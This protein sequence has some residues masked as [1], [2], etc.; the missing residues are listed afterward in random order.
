MGSKVLESKEMPYSE[1]LGGILVYT[2][3]SENF[4][5][6]LVK[7]ELGAERA[8]ELRRMW[9]QEIELIPEGASDKDKY[10]IA[11]R[12]FM[13]KWVHAMNFMTTHKGDAGTSKF[14]HAAIDAWKQKYATRAVLLKFVGSIS[15]KAAFRMLTKRMAY[16]LQAFS[17]FSV[18]EQNEDRMVLSVSPCKILSDQ[19]GSS[20]CLM[21]CQN[22]IPSWMEAQFNVKMNLNRKG[23]DCNVIFELFS[24]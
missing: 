1:K 23:E 20:F 17:P 2:Q 12:N 8:N 16:Q 14:M 11:Y 21:A 24:S 18:T 7:E 3:M 19:N 22:I 15:R 10:E 9:N 4:A 13:R 6:R 5:L